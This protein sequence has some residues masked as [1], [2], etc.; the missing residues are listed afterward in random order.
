MFNLHPENW[1]KRSN[2]NEYFS[3][4]LVQPV[5]RDYFQRFW[6]NLPG[7]HNFNLKLGGGFKY[8]LF[9]SLFGE[10]I[11][12]DEY[13]SDGLKPPPRKPIFKKRDQLG[14]GETLWDFIH[15]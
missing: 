4:G 12:F 13:F 9:S 2:F 3:N 1:G 5:A 10:M 11:L 6:G 15:W 8:F 7:F 14:E